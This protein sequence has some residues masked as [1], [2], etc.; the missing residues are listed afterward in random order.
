MAGWIS[1]LSTYFRLTGARP[2]MTFTD[3]FVEEV[4]AK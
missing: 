3:P 4:S 2:A 1:N